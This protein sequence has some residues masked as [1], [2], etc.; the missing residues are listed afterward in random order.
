[1]QT[2]LSRQS[3]MHCNARANNARDDESKAGRS[4]LHAAKRQPWSGKPEQSA[5]N[6][7]SV[8]VVVIGV[9]V[10]VLKVV[11]EFVEFVVSV[12]LA[13]MVVELTSAVVIGVVV[14]VEFVGV[15]VGAFWFNA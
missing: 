13:S 15:V 4:A 1:M 11:V 3:L 2:S 12:V 7:V 10:V 9:V 5:I 14:A 8:V 6:G